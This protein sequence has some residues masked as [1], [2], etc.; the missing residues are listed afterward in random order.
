MTPSTTTRAF[1]L[2]R[3]VDH[4][5]VQTSSYGRRP[6][7]LARVRL[8][9]YGSAR[10]ARGNY[11]LQVGPLALSWGPSGGVEEGRASVDDL[12]RWGRCWWLKGGER[13]YA[14]DWTR[15]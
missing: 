15:A 4:G 13:A 5:N 2:V 6:I 11:I 10:W 8:R 1:G 14:I 3:H 7:V 9:G 12:I